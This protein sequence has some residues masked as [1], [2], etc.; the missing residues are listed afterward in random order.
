MAERHLAQLNI[1]HLREPLDHPDLEPFVANLDGVNAEADAALGF[2][3]R[4]EDE[5]SGNATDLRPW[6]DDMIVNLSVWTDM[7]SLRTFVYA[8]GHVEVLR[9]RRQFF[10]PRQGPHMVL[11]WI[12]AGHIPTLDEAK[13]RLDLL[14]ARG[15][16]PEAFTFR[17]SSTSGPS[18]AAE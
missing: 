9:Q 5:E 7:E 10:T 8:P 15:E 4:L 11:W 18:S 17:E 2:V 13:E 16:S 12:P 6:G 14:E 1:A 3:W